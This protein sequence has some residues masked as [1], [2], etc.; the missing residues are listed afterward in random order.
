MC[1]SFHIPNV[2]IGVEYQ[3]CP[4]I[5]DVY[6]LFAI[7]METIQSKHICNL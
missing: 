5:L 4:Q 1:G 3:N 7:W 2:L 6:L